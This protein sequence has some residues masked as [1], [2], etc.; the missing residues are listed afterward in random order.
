MGYRAW[1]IKRVRS[2]SDVAGA[3]GVAEGSGVSRMGD[4]S[5]LEGGGKRGGA[6]G[7][8]SSPSSSSSSS[9]LSGRGILEPCASIA[10]ESGERGWTLPAL[11]GGELTTRGVWG[12]VVGAYPGGYC[13][14]D[15]DRVEG[16]DG[17]GGGAWC[18]R[19]RGGA[20]GVE[21]GTLGLLM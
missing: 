3:E 15:D 9:S 19:P 10:A 18:S 21:G 1:G 8:F 13:A 6:E 17:G 2:M 16:L 12:V 7:V 14:D 4:P 5:R 11:E 20:P